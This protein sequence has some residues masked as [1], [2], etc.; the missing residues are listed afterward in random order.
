LS[1]EITKLG[2]SLWWG[3]A[4]NIPEERRSQLHAD[5]ALRVQQK[6]NGERIWEIYWRSCGV[7]LDYW[8]TNWREE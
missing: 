4:H 8:Y 6:L 5:C 3:A 1:D 7:H 2:P